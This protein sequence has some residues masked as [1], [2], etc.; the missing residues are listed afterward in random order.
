MIEVFESEELMD[1]LALHKAIDEADSVVPCGNFP[2]AWFPEGDG[3]SIE[4]RWAKEMCHQCPV[5]RECGSFGLKW[6][7]LGIWGGLTGQDRR[8]IHK[9]LRA[10]R[11]A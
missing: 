1:W 8:Q 10:R 9:N 4:V 6:E 2:E 7:P 3:A 5:M 11:A